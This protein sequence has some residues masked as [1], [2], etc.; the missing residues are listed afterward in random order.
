LAEKSAEW[1][2]SV[3]AEIGMKGELGWNWLAKIIPA[4][5][6]KI[7]SSGGLSSTKEFAKAE[8]SAQH[9]IPLLKM[10]PIQ[11]VIEDF[12]YLADDVK[13][14][15]FQQWKSFVDE[16]VSVLVVSTTHKYNEMFSANPDLGGRIRV[17]DLS[18][19]SAADL[20]KIVE[21]GLKHLRVRHGIALR[22]YVA[23]ES[24]GI[25]IIAQQICYDFVREMDLSYYSN[26][27]RKDYHP[28]H[29]KPHV[30]AVAKEFYSEFER[31][32]DRL[33]DGPRSRARKY[34]TYSLILCS[35]VIDPVQF[36]LSKNDL[37]ARIDQICGTSG[38]IPVASLNSSLK[39]LQAYQ[40][41]IGRTLLE[42][43]EKTEMLHILEP[44]FLFYVRQRAIEDQELGVTAPNHLTKLINQFGMAP[45]IRD[46]IIK[47]N[48]GPRITRVGKDRSKPL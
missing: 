2:M 3:G 33:C 11:L 6:L 44:T 27:L 20:G 13:R 12:H 47:H 21:K 1:G 29:V 41:R 18:Q 30:R 45:Y 17:I 7:D 32:Y 9:I 19:W 42:W 34:D 4:L 8:L 37:L 35:F 5:N 23:R 40:K 36:S 25:P 38:S 24:T 16:G 48:A 15:L 43:Q 28:D 46:N 14:E 39:A 10:L 26:S 31:D 22:E